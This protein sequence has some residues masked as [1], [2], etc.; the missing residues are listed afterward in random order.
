M[1]AFLIC[2]AF[3]LASCSTP[4]G[5]GSGPT[6]TP[7]SITTQPVNQVVPMGRPATFSVV[8][9]S[10]TTPIH[11][12]WS[13]NGVA[14]AGATSTSYTTQN[15]TLADNG[16]TFQVTVSNAANSTT[17]NTATLTAGPRAPAIGDLRYLLYQQVT[18]P[19]FGSNGN[20]IVTDVY[21][22][23]SATFS[24]GLGSPL[25][26]GPGDCDPSTLRCYY[27]FFVW[28]LPEPM[29]GYSTSYEAGGYD[30]NY[31]NFDSWL[32]SSIAASDVVITSLDLETSS[33]S[34]GLSWVKADQGQAFD[35]RMEAIAPQQIQ[36]T[37]TADG[38]AGRIITA[39]TFDDT[40]GKAILISYGWQGDTTTAYEAQTVVTASQNVAASAATLANQGYFI[41]AFGGNDT[42]GYILVGM[43]AMGDTMPRPVSVG[44]QEGTALPQNPDSAYYTT[45]VYLEYNGD[46]ALIQEQ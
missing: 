25:L 44:T 22:G 18:V 1:T 11:Y 41:S 9:A 38:A 19:W 34:F 46:H 42:D 37:A 43:R 3:L 36:A 28:Y 33:Q 20:G 23:R 14:I 26:L 8:A 7:V 24:N 12:Q 32:Q 27:L 29:T 10:Y 15:V 21:N 16:S 31:S 5:Y 40:S 4:A 17:S 35:Y 2:S 39:A 13:R 6:P 45:V 30:G